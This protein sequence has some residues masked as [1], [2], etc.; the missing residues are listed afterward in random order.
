MPRIR[1]VHP[2]L[3]TDEAW[4]SCTPLARLLFI[5][6]WTEAD[7]QG[8]F[9]WKPLQIKMRL[10]GGDNADP[11]ELLAELERA[12]CIRRFDVDG[13]RYGAV[14]N[15]RKWQR[16][17]KPNAIHPLPDDMAVYV[18]L[19]GAGAHPFAE[20]SRTGTL[21]VEEQSP[22]GPRNPPQMED[23]GWKRDREDGKKEGIPALTR[24]S[25]PKAIADGRGFAAFW[26]AYPTKIGKREAV[27]AYA[28]AVKRIVAADPTAE[29]NSVILNAVEAALVGS[30][31][32][33]EGFVPNP[34]TWLNRDGWHDE[35]S[36]PPRISR[37][38]A[39]HLDRL[40]AVDAAMKAA[41]GTATDDSAQSPHLWGVE[42]VPISEAQV[43]DALF[44]DLGDARPGRNGDVH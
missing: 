13:K 12:G 33:R 1:S 5:G 37:K 18:G 10:L 6:L 3:F 43:I 2:G 16:P 17:Q 40:A 36:E 28:K 22:T 39:E 21:T 4:V 24:V 19:S 30:R 41:M 20:Q 11:V 8:V 34:A 25:D 29:P 23:G 31:K 44:L 35:H 42:A 38:Q 9:E 32:W 26:R 27:K 15:F 7:D 14:R